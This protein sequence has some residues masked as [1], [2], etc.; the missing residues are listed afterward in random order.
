MLDFA[1]ITRK[2]ALSAMQQAE[3]Q[4]QQQPT[5]SRSPN[6]TI[7]DNNNNNN[8]SMLTPGASDVERDSPHAK[9]QMTE[10]LDD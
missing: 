10:I 7:P 5:A 9:K 3:Q 1:K 8:S 2:R 6:L 4:Q